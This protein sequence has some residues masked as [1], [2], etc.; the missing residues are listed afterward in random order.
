[1]NDIETSL[2]GELNGLIDS[3]NYIQAI[4]LIQEHPEISNHSP[5]RKQ[6][7]LALSRIG[8]TEQAVHVL[9]PLRKAS[10]SDPEVQIQYA[11]LMKRQ[12]IR[13]GSRKSLEKAYRGYADAFKAHGDYWAGIN[14]ATL[15]RLMN[16][17]H[18]SELADE[19][20]SICWEE[21]GRMGTRS[22]FWLLVTI[23]EAYLVKGEVDT[24]LKWYSMISPTAYKSVGQVKTIRKNARLLGQALGEEAL[25][26]LMEGI[27]IP[28]IAFFAGH[29]IDRE[30]MP[31]RFPQSE[32]ETVKR[33]LRAKLGKMRI[34]VGVASLADGADILFHECLIESG[35][36]NR[37]ILPCPID[38]FR[39][40]LKEDDPGGWLE[41]FDNVASKSTMVETV[42]RSVFTRE[43]DVVHEFATD[44]MLGYSISLANE[45]DGEMIPIVVWDEKARNRS[46]GTY[47]AVKKLRKL[48]YE[49][50]IITVF[51]RMNTNE[52]PYD[53]DDA[54]M[55]SDLLPTRNIIIVV[56]IGRDFRVDD[57][58]A[59][60]LST[61]ARDI[62]STL[63][64]K[65]PYPVKRS[66][67][68]KEICLQFRDIIQAMDFAKSF[69]AMHPEASM[70]LHAGLS[71]KF[72]VSMS[73]TTD[74]F[75]PALLEAVDLSKKLV[76]GQLFAT[77]AFQSLACL[78]EECPFTFDYRGKFKTE[79][80]T[81]RLFEIL[82]KKEQ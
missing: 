29:R 7:A 44:Y 25:Q 69:S 73:Q 72:D 34:S 40:K 79:S 47:S 28:R 27:Y 31:E 61:L 15:A 8:Q 55:A 53:P 74:T 57:K 3:G 70:A 76:S 71:V 35:R 56:G 59:D 50:E 45:L 11:G 19:V 21:Y 37:V 81:L 36:Q 4:D 48:G 30:G 62:E 82:P 60:E 17:K 16:E 68:G 13:S 18:S 75:S 32:S 42:T 22:S 33:K 49:P 77:T 78:E 58:I 54:L 67:N 64:S 23:A 52:S 12:W 51:P 63:S 41:R 14:A 20:L 46:G 6:Y 5:L 66:L 80:A 9:E 2:C 39:A 26:T 38:D 43:W 1:M 65:K 24:A 10:K